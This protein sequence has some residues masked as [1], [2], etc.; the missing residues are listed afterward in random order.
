LVDAT[1]VRL[2]SLCLL[3]L[4]LETWRSGSGGLQISS[5]ESRATSVGECEEDACNGYLHEFMISNEI[6]FGVSFKTYHLKKNGWNAEAG[7][8]GFLAFDVSLLLR[9]AHALELEVA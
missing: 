2:S 9:T 8:C 6:L 4:L 3:C 5:P 1:R 7:V